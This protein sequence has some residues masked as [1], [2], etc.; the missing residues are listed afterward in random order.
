MKRLWVGVGMLLVLMGIGVVTAASMRCVHEPVSKLLSQA[1]QA[2]LAEDWEQAEKLSDHAKEQWQ[3]HWHATAA[4][5][6][7]E[8]ME[9]IDSLFAELAVYLQTKEDVH[10]AA[11]CQNLSTLTRAVGEA[12]AINWWNLM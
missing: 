4:L 9:Q 8:P 12:H 1:S 6:D 7:H 5:A 10:F 2:A 11:C 3:Q